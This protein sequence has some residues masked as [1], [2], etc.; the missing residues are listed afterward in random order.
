[1]SLDVLLGQSL[2]VIDIFIILIYTFYGK[3]FWHK[4]HSVLGYRKKI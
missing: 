1:M 2:C 3:K 4:T